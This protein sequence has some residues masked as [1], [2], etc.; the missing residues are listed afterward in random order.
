[1]V[2]KDTRKVETMDIKPYLYKQTKNIEMKTLVIHPE[3]RSTEFLSVIYK[4]IP[5]ATIIR[6]EYPAK[7]DI[8]EVNELI[9]SHDRVIMMGHGCYDGLFSIGLFKNARGLIIDNQTADL[10]REKTDNVYIWCHANQYVEK[11]GLKGFYSGMF[12]SEV[13]EARCEGFRNTKQDEVTTSNNTFAE[14]LS[15]Y[16]NEDSKTIQENVTKEYGVLAETSDVASYN[17]CRLKVL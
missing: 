7:M 1:M 15:K 13:G 17:N 2:R 16:I 12:I 5:D 8:S 3:D 14:I 4:D 11:H 6:G 10:L 9:K